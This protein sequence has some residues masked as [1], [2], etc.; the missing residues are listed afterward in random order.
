MVKLQKTFKLLTL[1]AM[2]F[3]GSNVSGQGITEGKT[4]NQMLVQSSADSKIL[5]TQHI[6]A[7]YNWDTHS[8]EYEDGDLTF[9][10]YNTDLEELKS[11]DFSYLLN[12]VTGEDI[13]K[14][15]YPYFKFVGKN[16]FT[17]SGKY[18]FLLI[19]D[20]VSGIY[21]EDGNKIYALPDVIYRDDNDYEHPF[22]TDG[23]LFIHA[24]DTI[25]YYE[26]YD[27]PMVV[28]V[29]K[30]YNLAGSN[31]SSI[32][33][34]QQQNPTRLYPNPAKHSVILEYNIQGQMQE[35]QI[36]NT[37]GR[38]VASYLL[39]PSQKQVKINTSNYK[40]GVYIYRYGN[41][42]GKFTVQ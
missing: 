5:H 29:T 18:E 3:V 10:I 15:F 33:A 36:V 30:S 13:D 40:K 37:Q 12:A 28:T 39:D 25:G 32:T 38:V 2:L 26:E 11:I 31:A 7:W 16:I 14:G 24:Y 19:A 23:K 42:S 9:K 20:K 8:F 6:W 34:V 35:M 4:C 21:D 22:I 17:N 27:E 41:N 1:A